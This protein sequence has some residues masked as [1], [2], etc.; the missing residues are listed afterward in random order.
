M[1]TYHLHTVGGCAVMKHF[2]ILAC[3]MVLILL[4]W[5]CKRA[6]REEQDANGAFRKERHAGTS[7]V[8]RIVESGE[9]IVATLSGP[10]TYFEYQGRG[11][12]LQYALAENFAESLG[13]SVRVEICTDTLQMARL[14]EKGEADVA[15]LQMPAD[16]ARKM[17]LCA[18]GA[19]SKDKSGRKLSWMVGA[20][21]GD[22]AQALDTWYG[23]GVELK[24]EKVEQKRLLQRREVRRKVRAPFISREKGIISIYDN[25]FRQAA[26]VLG[27]DWRLVAAQCYQE[28]GYDPNAVSWAG[29]S[30]LMQLMPATAAQYHLPQ[31][32]IFQPAENIAAATRFLKHLQGAYNGI[33]DPMER[34]KFV[35][36]AYN[37][38]PG[39]IADAQALARKYGR[40]PH[41]WEDVG[42]FVRN[43]SQVQYYRDPVVKHGYMIGNETFNYVASIM[44]RWAQYGG[45]ATRP[46][47]PHT[48]PAGGDGGS[49]RSLH[50]RN[51]YSQQQKIL[52]ADKLAGA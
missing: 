31:E 8:D 44:D 30:G 23:D 13:V 51:R 15:A 38:G 1:Q 18:A 25:Y 3:L 39:H 46:M 20:E 17:G 24:V 5:G 36:A 26:S 33:T 27:W 14:V 45:N 22:L 2:R 42:F 29:A 43:L 6:A 28:S 40:N 21:S 10:D 9:L 4:V 47:M 41:S 12:G 32:S 19:N 11:F 37:A 34:V 7:Q 48:S 16:E 35:L 50:K 49:Q 52:D